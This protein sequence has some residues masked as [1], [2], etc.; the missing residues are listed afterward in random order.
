MR[1][2]IYSKTFHPSVGG[3]EVTSR[4]LAQA[5]VALGHQVQV[6]TSTPLPPDA[7]LNEGYEIHRS[8]KFG[9]CLHAARNSGLVISKGGVSLTAGG[10]ALLSGTPLVIWHEMFSRMPSGS[11]SHRTSP[12]ALLRCAVARHARLHVAVSEACLRSKHLD[13]RTKTIVIPNPISP[14]LARAAAQLRNPIRGACGFRHDVLF[15][16]RLIRTKGV[17]VLAEALQHLASRGL[18]IRA[19]FAGE[20]PDGPLLKRSL[21][22]AG[23]TGVVFTGVLSE[24]QLAEVYRGSRCLVLP[25]L[26]PE[27]MGMVLVEAFA[28]GVPAIGSDQCGMREVIGAAGLI[29]PTGDA[30]GLARRIGD[31]LLAEDVAYQALADQALARS[32]AFT[33]S[34]YLRRVQE[35]LGVIRTPPAHV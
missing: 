23:V 14:G 7:E 2:S 6:L 31:L 35:A 27:G 18:R 13:S 22:N 20:G 10:A 33:Y 24:A 16:G 12:V 30:R 32:R 19:C 1:I 4:V 26:E 9:D 28:F 8:A 15:V 29:S 25:S 3:M 34:D 11:G 5:L 17:F 21:C